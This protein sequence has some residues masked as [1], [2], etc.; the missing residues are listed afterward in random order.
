[1]KT[2]LVI[3]H[4]NDTERLEPFLKELM[5][6]LPLRFTILVSDDGSKSS[7]QE[8]LTALIGKFRSAAPLSHPQLLDPI[9]IPKNTGKGGAVYR[10][11]N[12][13][14]GFSLLAFC[15]AD[16]A[17]SAKEV[18]RAESFFHSQ[19]CMADALFASRI[20]MLGRSVERSLVRHFSGRAFATLVSELGRIPAYD[21]QCGLKILTVEAYREI[22]PY[23]HTKDFAFDVEL[24]MLLLKK[25]CRVI[26]FPVDWHDV[27][28]S[29]V[30]LL[31][32]AIRMTLQVLKIQ[33]RIKSLPR[34]H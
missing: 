14:E 33:R 26:E 16:G 9:F 21:T 31:R 11:W 19:E 34:N 30:R 18:L 4:F 13:R 12:F 6:T 1:M 32:D 10:G 25:G 29:K 20:K 2:L 3:P 27:P 8:R 15:D 28:G 23:L 7:E 22:H 5:E 17:V 24:A